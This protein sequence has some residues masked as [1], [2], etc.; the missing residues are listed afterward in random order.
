MLVNNPLTSPVLAWPT[1]VDSHPHVTDKRGS[2]HDDNLGVYAGLHHESN[3]PHNDDIFDDIFDGQLYQDL[4]A[5]G[6]SPFSSLHVNAIYDNNIVEES[7]GSVSKGLINADNKGYDFMPPPQ[8][9]DLYDNNPYQSSNNYLDV[10][11]KEE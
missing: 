6:I 9:T 3:N 4:D 8:S 11:A 10:D 1:L 7:S 5:S 2:V